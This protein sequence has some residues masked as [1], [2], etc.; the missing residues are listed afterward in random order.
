VIA[1]QYFR[2][3]GTPLAYYKFLRILS[4]I[5]LVVSLVNFASYIYEPNAVGIVEVLVLTTIRIFVLV[6]LYGK[7]WSGVVALICM[8]AFYIIELL[9]A[10][11]IYIY[12][13]VVTAKQRC[14]VR[15]Q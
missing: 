14:F 12:F 10:F 8:F 4:I 9:I 6:G 1:P 11:G 5:W 2:E 13:D 7:K 3:E 15:P